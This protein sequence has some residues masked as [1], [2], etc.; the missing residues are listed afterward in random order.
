[1]DDKKNEL[2]LIDANGK[3]YIGEWPSEDVNFDSLENPAIL[4]MNV[5]PSQSR[6]AG[7]GASFVTLAH[8]LPLPIDS[9]NFGEGVEITW[10]IINDDNIRKQYYDTMEQ[11]K[12]PLVSNA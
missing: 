6:V 5:V 1:M 9:L 10:G 2:V 3:L 12:K 11:I 8:I 4:A 7:A